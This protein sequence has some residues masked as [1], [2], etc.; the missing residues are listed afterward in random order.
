MTNMRCDQDAQNDQDGDENDDYEES[1]LAHGNDADSSG[2]EIY[3]KQKR[4]SRSLNFSIKSDLRLKSIFCRRS[5]SL[6]SR[7]SCST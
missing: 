7:K 6:N 5:M 1:T 2:T 4:K 3:I